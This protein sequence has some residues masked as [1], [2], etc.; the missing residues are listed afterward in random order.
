[1]L[2]KI[3][4]FMYV[5][6]ALLWALPALA[7]V[8]PINEYSGSDMKVS[9]SEET[10]TCASYPNYYETKQ[11][12]ARCTQRTLTNGKTKC[13]ECYCDKSTY[14]FTASQCNSE[15]FV[16][17]DSARCTVGDVS[18]YSNCNC[19]STKNYLSSTLYVDNVSS[20]FTYG[21]TNASISG[22]SGKNL[23][24]YQYD[25]FTCKTGSLLK[26][27]MLSSISGSATSTKLITKNN[28]DS[29]YL[30]YTAKSTLKSISDSKTSFCTT[31][32][33][34][35]APLSKSVPTGNDCAEYSTATANYFNNQAYYYFNGNCS[36]NG[37]CLGSGNAFDCVV[38]SSPSVSTY[39]PDSKTAGSVSCRFTSGCSI[40]M[41]TKDDGTKYVCAG[42]NNTTINGTDSTQINSNYFNLTNIV[43]GNV[44]CR[45]VD[46]CANEY[47]LHTMKQVNTALEAQIIRDDIS[48]NATEDEMY[49]YDA[50]TLGIVQDDP[51]LYSFTVCRKPS[52]CNIDNGYYDIACP[53]GCWN[54]LLSWWYGGGGSSTST[55]EEVTTATF[56]SKVLNASG[57]AVVVF[58]T[59]WCGP[60]KMML[61]NSQLQALNGVDNV[62][63]YQ[64]NSENSASIADS[65]NVSSLP[66]TVFFKGGASVDS[67]QGANISTIVEKINTLK[68]SSDSGG[69]S[70]DTPVMSKWTC[71]ICGYVHEGTTA[72]SSCP[73]CGA[74]QDEFAKKVDYTTCKK[75]DALTINA[76][77]GGCSSSIDDTA[78]SV[79]MFF[80]KSP[81]DSNKVIAG[82]IASLRA[83]IG[84]NSLQNNI[85]SAATLSNVEILYANYCNAASGGYSTTSMNYIYNNPNLVQVANNW[86]QVSY[87]GSDFCIIGTESVV[88]PVDVDGNAMAPVTTFN[89]SMCPVTVFICSREESLL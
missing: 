16:P 87:P 78:K 32:V 33:T 67:V 49:L 15:G 29:P 51:E 62:K 60:C 72:P 54:G 65:Y 28:Y 41:I 13:W 73:I 68:N 39:N 34:P 85:K 10:Y 5:A 53:T 71:N 56:S 25:K 55:I 42:D 66:T 18:T 26:P 37:K 17:D 40:G 89:T 50:Q 79:L 61:G 58:T 63:I 48:L 35:N 23:T 7:R 80:A 31:A 43:A 46:G 69:D 77:T 9:S 45:K 83:S 59:D 88:L 84:N 30:T 76:S 74:A 64:V 22:S 38:A 75:G 11:Y 44:T 6:A 21:G 24:C 2:T 20:A 82:N 1:M 86:V 47:E 81:T 70:G 27:D 19:N 12:N 57:L 4:N 3:K 36:T 52:G 14:Q 8:T